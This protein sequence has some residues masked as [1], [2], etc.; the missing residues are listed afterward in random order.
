MNLDEQYMYRA[1]QLAEIAGVNTA[2]NPMVGAVIVHNNRIIGEGFHERCGQA[3]AEVNA[4]RQVADKKLLREATIYVTLEPCAH[5]GKTPPCAALL[6]HHQF[7]RVVVAT[8]DPFAKVAG[9]GLQ[10]LTNAGIETKVG[11][12]EKQAQQLNKRFFTFHQQQRPYVILKWAQTKDGFID[13]PRKKDDTGQIR[14]I[15]QPETQVLTH[16][17]RSEEQAILVGWKTILNDN[18]SLTARAF[19][20]PHPLRI[21]VDPSL[22]APQTA[23]VFSDG[24]PTL[25]FNTLKSETKN[26]VQFVQLEDLTVKSIL[27]ELYR[28]N[29]LSVLIEGGS[30]TLQQFIRDSWWDEARVIQG[31]SYFSE[32]TKAPEMTGLPQETIPFNQDTLFY[33]FNK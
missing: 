16:R 15:S 13:A 9:L 1:L 31:I 10:M 5:Y 24:L 7:K 4:V 30:F 6:V 23:T 2:P 25:V 14:W 29:I 21:V 19:K 32:G 33:Y 26:A 28:R 22:K 18:P 12:L 20:G 11:V 8:V 3:H 17:W 27:S